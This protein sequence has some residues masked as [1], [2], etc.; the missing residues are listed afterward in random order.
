[1]G[2]LR[3]VLHASVLITWSQFIPL[4]SGT[5]LPPPPA[6][7]DAWRVGGGCSLLRKACSEIGPLFTFPSFQEES[8]RRRMFI[9]RKRD[10]WLRWADEPKV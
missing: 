4:P 9:S 2:S 1:M 3:S 10:L 7:R 6:P 5:P 8:I